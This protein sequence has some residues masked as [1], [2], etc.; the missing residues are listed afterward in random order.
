MGKT[1]PRGKYQGVSLSVD[2][3]QEIK[4]HIMK[5]ERYKSI[6]EF[7]RDACREKMEKI[8]DSK[9]KKII[10]EIKIKDGTNE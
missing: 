10:I 5:D 4:N 9:L 1:K 2:F 6:A 3:V 7:V 8:S